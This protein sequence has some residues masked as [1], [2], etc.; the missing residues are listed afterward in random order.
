MTK[1]QLALFFFFLSVLL[2]AQETPSL[3][4][5]EWENLKHAWRASWITHPVSNPLDYSVFHFR[6]SFQLES[7]PDSLLVHISA[8]NR[9]RFYVNGCYVCNGPSRGDRLHWRYE[10]LDIAPYLNKGKNVLAAVVVNFGVWKPVAQHSY[11][12]AFLLQADRERF[13]HLNTGQGWKACENKAYHPIPVSESMVH[14]FYAVAPGDSVDGRRY[15]WGW[16]KVDYNDVS[17]LNAKVIAR[18]VGRGYMHGEGWY[19][20]PRSIPLLEE[21]PESLNHIVRWEGMD[22]NQVPSFPIRIPPFGNVTLLIDRRQLTMGYPK[23]DV[24]NGKNSTIKISYGE[25]LFDSTGKKGHRND[26]RKKRVEGLYD[27]YI[28]DGGEH[29]RFESLWLRTFRYVQLEIQTG[30]E[31]LIINDYVNL[32]TAYPF[33]HKARFSCSDTTLHKIWRTSWRTARLCAQETYYDCPYYEQLQYIGDTRIQALISLTNSGDSRLMKKAITL[34]DQSRIPEGL[35]RS[36][37]PSHIDQ[38]IPPFSLLW[39]AMVHDYF[40]HCDDV[41]TVRSLLPGVRA[42]LDYFYRHLDD[43]YFITMV[44]WFPFVDWADGWAWGVPPGVDL[45]QSAILTLQYLYAAQRAMDLFEYFGDDFEAQSLRRIVENVQ[46]GLRRYCYDET[47]GLFADTPEKQQFS[48]HTNVLAVL[49]DTAPRDDQKQLMRNV[50]NQSSLTSCTLYFKFYLF[51]AMKKAGL[52]ETY[53]E[54]LNPWKQALEFGL[55]TFPENP[56]GNTSV[57]GTRSDCHAW[58]ASPNFDFL[59]TICGIESAAPGFSEVHIQPA[60]GNLKWVKGEMPHPRGV[61]KVEFYREAGFLKGTV[62]LPSFVKGYFQ[63]RES[64]RSLKAGLNRIET[65]HE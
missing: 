10:T 1:H 2:Q 9:Y 41:E 57:V 17:W 63:W 19:L 13:Y 20:T 42:V 22:G 59:A 49:T 8:D 12:T 39:I 62:E 4:N 28:A 33:E 52:G 40:Q 35:T 48:Q 58:S 51:R 43:H 50:L 61:I 55:T 34:F 14:G 16:R 21:K 23:L 64:S 26:I 37:Y 60:L 24:S 5:Q 31:A 32:F 47:S 45:G 65:S 53:L 6:R 25:A 44:E 11:R 36:R 15:P 18:A 30:D 7:I 46:H 38:F 56:I 3:V 29:R 27:I 54:Q